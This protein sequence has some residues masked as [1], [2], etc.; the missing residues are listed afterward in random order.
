MDGME[1]FSTV[2]FVTVMRAV[3]DELRS[4]WYERASEW[5]SVE[6]YVALFAHLWWL[7]GMDVRY[8]ARVGLGFDRRVVIN[9]LI[10]GHL[11]TREKTLKHCPCLQL[12]S[13]D[14]NGWRECLNG[15]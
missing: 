13:S 12:L 1:V 3:G 15:S 2:A 10:S 6:K 4:C 9:I 14:K 7:S 5:S 11:E 8:G